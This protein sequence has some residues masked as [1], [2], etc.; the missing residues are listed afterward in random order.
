MNRI[1]FGEK[2]SWLSQDIILIFAGENGEHQK[3][4]Q[5]G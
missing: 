4:P 5:T 1:G 3:K 2:Q